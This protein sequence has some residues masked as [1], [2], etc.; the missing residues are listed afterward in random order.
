MAEKRRN[1]R[2]RVQTEI[3]VT[4]GE[5][6]VVGTTENLSLGGAMFR[7]ELEPTLKIGE[8][9]GISFELPDLKDRVKAEAEVRWV[10]G[11]DAAT[12]G[13]QFTT[14]LRAKET[15]ALNQLLSRLE[16]DPG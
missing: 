8:R 16:P 9:V 5:T 3:E 12:V 2:F 15:W 6:R 7:A 11:T 4:R 13:V 10:S 1:Q 14:G